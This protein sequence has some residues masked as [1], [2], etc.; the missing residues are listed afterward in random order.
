[1]I[2]PFITV[3]MATHDSS[4]HDRIHEIAASCNGITVSTVTT[5]NCTYV[6]KY[7]YP[8]MHDRAQCSLLLRMYR[9]DIKVFEHEHG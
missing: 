7:C 9:A 6:A 5:N 3:A 2:T 1:M 4:A 8:S